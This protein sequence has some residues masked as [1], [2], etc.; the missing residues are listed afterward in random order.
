LRNEKDLQLPYNAH[1]E[2]VSLVAGAPARK[3]LL[4]NEYFVDSTYMKGR[5][6][7]VVVIARKGKHT[8]FV[9]LDCVT[10]TLHW[11]PEDGI[12]LPN[13]V[14]YRR[15]LPSA[16]NEHK[17]AVDIV[18]DTG[19]VFRASG[20]VDVGRSHHPTPSFAVQPNHA[21][22]YKH[23][24][25]AYEMEFNAEQVLLPVHPMRSVCVSTTMWSAFRDPTPVCA[26]VHPHAMKY[27]VRMDDFS[28]MT[29]V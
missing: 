12:Q 2:P 6:L 27:A 23:V 17:L 29:P 14:R 5:R 10:D 15:T 8:H 26:F 13:S 3:L 16:Y 22:F 21:C 7:E 25:C 28:R 9:V 24:D 1:V 11:N 19:A 4:F 18:R 20:I